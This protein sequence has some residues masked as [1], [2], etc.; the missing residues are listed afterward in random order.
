MHWTALGARIAGILGSGS[1]P[2]FLSAPWYEVRLELEGEQALE[3]PSSSAWEAFSGLDWVLAGLSALTV[4]L[5]ALSFVLPG[6][7]IRLSAALA[8]VALLGVLIYAAVVTPGLNEPARELGALIETD[9]EVAREWG[10]FA[11]LAGG[12][13]ASVSAV[14]LLLVGG[15]QKTCPDCATRVPAKARVCRECGYRFEGDS[16]SD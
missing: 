14:A 16:A 10:L 11:A 6:T 15:E 5:L 2:L 13:V 4:L 3:A 9:Y 1:V 12:V 7:L 8:S